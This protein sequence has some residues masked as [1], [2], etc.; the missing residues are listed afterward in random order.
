MLLM[1]LQ[2]VQPSLNYWAWHMQRF[3]DIRYVLEM[4]NLEP[5]AIAENDV[6]SESY[7][8]VLFLGQNVS[9]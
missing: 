1:G 3:F 5:S 4:N 9:E 6:T 7:F 8:V 2:L